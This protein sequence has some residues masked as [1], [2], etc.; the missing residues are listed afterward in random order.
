M[1]T[2]EPYELSH[3]ELAALIRAEPVRVTPNDHIPRLT[4]SFFIHF[5]GK[6][7]GEWKDKEEERKIRQLY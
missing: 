5:K 7:A 2:S 1:A 3:S 4:K 6:H